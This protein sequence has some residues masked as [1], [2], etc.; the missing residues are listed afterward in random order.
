MFWQNFVF[1]DVKLISDNHIHNL[2][3]EPDEKSQ[4]Y[5]LKEAVTIEDYHQDKETPQKIAK[6]Y[7]VGSAI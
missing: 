7:K 1:E 6:A 5:L 4:H 3:E 2:K